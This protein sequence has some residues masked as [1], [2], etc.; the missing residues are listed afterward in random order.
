MPMR[1][2]G[3]GLRS[4]TRMS[5]A[6]YWASWAD[7]L[8]MISQRLPEVANDIVTQLAGEPVGC[9]AE[10]QGAAND[11]DRCGFV[12][13]PSWEALKAGA[14]PPAPE[15]TEPGE[16]LHGWQHLRLLLPS[17]T[18]S[19]SSVADQA[20]L[21][22]H[23]G[24][25]AGSWFHGS[26]TQLEYQVQPVLFRTLLLERM[27]L[28]LQITEARC[29]CGSQLDKLGRHRGACPRF[30]RTLARVCREAGAS[31]RCKCRL[32]DMN[33]TVRADDE[34]VLEVLAS[35]LPLHHGAQLAVDITLQSALTAAGLPSPS[36]A[37]VNG[38][39]SARARRDRERKYGELLEG[40]R[41]HTGRRWSQEA[42]N[43]VTS[44]AAGRCRDVPPILRR[45]ARLVWQRRWLRMLAI[46]CGKAF[47][48]SLLSSPKDAWTGTEGR[49]P[50]LADLFAEI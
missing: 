14:R 7:A 47:A 3:L 11:L 48:A 17:S 12:E 5:P 49:T 22:S 28:P 8:H 9:L 32:R 39:A 45:S 50:D 1:M 15:V 33:V 2:G 38:A 35:G 31:V 36:A 24:P 27:R 29:E 26:P 19:Q 23:S 21:R 18:L 34:R 20:H 30:E 43:F 6:P 46:S 42:C 4:A 37:H 40:D 41:C 44:L 16:W 25:S 13:R 10:L